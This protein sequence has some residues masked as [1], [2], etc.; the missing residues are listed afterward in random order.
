[1]TT[2][3]VVAAIDNFHVMVRKD[4]KDQSDEVR[5]E[6]KEQSRDIKAIEIHLGKIALQSTAHDETLYDLEHGV[7]T[8]MTTLEVKQKDCPA[9]QSSKTIRNAFISAVVSAIVT[10]IIAG[11]FLTA[12]QPQAH[13]ATIKPPAAVS[14]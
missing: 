3:A 2:A 10:G 13:A 9:R 12:F 4:L 7:V 1:M 6:L 14:K 8:R 5:K 11:A